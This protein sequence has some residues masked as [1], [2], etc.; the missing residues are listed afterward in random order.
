MGV[1][2]CSVAYARHQELDRCLSAGD[3]PLTACVRSRSIEIVVGGWV[4]SLSMSCT[5]AMALL[6]SA[7]L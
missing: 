3:R 1:C 6:P 4:W 2:F 7:N 5:R